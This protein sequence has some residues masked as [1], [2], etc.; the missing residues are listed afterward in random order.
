MNDK[1]KTLTAHCGLA[2]FLCDL[3]KDNI[4]KIGLN[5]W[6]GEEAEEIRAKY[7]TGTFIVGKG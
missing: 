2:C 4:K 5:R 6:T 3:Y 7:F 1:K